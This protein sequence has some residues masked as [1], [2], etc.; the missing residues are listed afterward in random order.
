M[1]CSNHIT[2]I[3]TFLFSVFP[4]PARFFGNASSLTLLSRAL[5]SCRQM[6]TVTEYQVEWGVYCENFAMIGQ[7]ADAGDNI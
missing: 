3:L 4:H 1:Y 2:C 5:K 7:T 6:D